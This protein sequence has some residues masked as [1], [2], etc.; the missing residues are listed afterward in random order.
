[1]VRPVL[2]ALTRTST[3]TSIA[4]DRSSSHP[5]GR[6]ISRPFLFAHDQAYHSLTMIQ[7]IWGKLSGAGIGLALGGPIGA[8]MG[9]VAGHMLVDREGAPFGK[10]PR[11]VMF[12]MGLV[13]LSA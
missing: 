3:A 1:A 10:P 11:D 9:G 12:T 7:S 2:T 6:E 8:L 13:A 4:A 5:K